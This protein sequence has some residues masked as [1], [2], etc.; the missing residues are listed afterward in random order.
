MTELEPHLHTRINRFC[1]IGDTLA[2]EGKY[3]DAVAAYQYAWNLLPDPKENWEA[4]TWIQT[5]IGDAHFLNGN[6]AAALI[7]LKQAMRC[8]DA[9]GNPFIHLRLGQTQFELDNKDRAADELMR[10]YMGAG[11]EIF[12][13]EAPKYLQYLGTVA[14]NIE[15]PHPLQ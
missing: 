11:A 14:E 8:P 10:A 7:A 1:E 2:A 3:S 4:A 6:Y 12:V 15:K 5:A 13:G 9:I